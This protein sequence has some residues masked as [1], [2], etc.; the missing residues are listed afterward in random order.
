MATRKPNHDGTD[1]RPHGYR[2]RDSANESPQ[3]GS[4]EAPTRNHDSESA[5][6]E[7]DEMGIPDRDGK[8]I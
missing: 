7:A 6:L 8:E 1:E 5:R 3:K 2:D 4:R